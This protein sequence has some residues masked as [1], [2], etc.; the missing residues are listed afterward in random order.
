MPRA[1]YFG[2]MAGA[3]PR[4]AAEA[5]PAALPEGAV[6]ADGAA[7]EELDA[8]ALALALALAEA[9]GEAVEDVAPEA[10]GADVVF[11]LVD[12]FWLAVVVAPSPPP[13]AESASATVTSPNETRLR[14]D[15]S[16]LSMRRRTAPCVEVGARERAV[17]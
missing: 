13:H 12:D 8:L 4:G 5:E 3:V 16:S 1:R 7:D 14:M 2:G 17:P 10:L 15:P 6:L 11:A 9:G